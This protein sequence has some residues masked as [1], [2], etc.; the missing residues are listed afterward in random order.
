MAEKHIEHG[1]KSY[2]NFF[3]FK[4]AF[5]RVWQEGLW[6][7]MRHFNIDENIIAIIENLYKKNLFINKKCRFG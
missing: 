4:K 7:V 3:D 2:H 1:S 6:K 5:N